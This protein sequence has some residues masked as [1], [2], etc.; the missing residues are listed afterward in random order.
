MA[1]PVRAERHER[2]ARDQNHRSRSVQKEGGAGETRS[3][4]ESA[5]ARQGRKSHRRGKGNQSPDVQAGDR[6]RRIP[7]TGQ[8]ASPDSFRPSRRRQ[9][10]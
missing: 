2:P 9:K 3:R 10:L 6:V 8:T 4:H 1:R 7:D 5:D